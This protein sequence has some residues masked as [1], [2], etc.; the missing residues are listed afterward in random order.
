MAFNESH[1]CLVRVIF[2]AF[3]TDFSP[4]AEGSFWV[5]RGLP[6]GRFGGSSLPRL[7]GALLGRLRGGL[8]L[9]LLLAGLLLGA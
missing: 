5:F 3:L 9:R 4:A 2:Q 7:K 6:R 1:L 8:A